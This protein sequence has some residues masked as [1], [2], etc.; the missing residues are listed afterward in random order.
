MEHTPVFTIKWALFEWMNE[1]MAK[2]AREKISFT[3]YG[4]RMNKRKIVAQK[5]TKT[6]E[7]CQWQKVCACV[8]KYVRKSIT[9]LL[10]SIEYSRHLTLCYTFQWS[11][12]IFLLIFVKKIWCQI[13]DLKLKTNLQVNFFIAEN[14]SN[15]RKNLPSR[16]GMYLAFYTLNV[17]S[18]KKWSTL[19]TLVLLCIRENKRPKCGS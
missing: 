15:F 2:Y 17:N 9:S 18:D 19:I 1:W 14:I 11:R 13:P 16:F 6:M 8:S 10:H 5:I 12:A 3:L 7:Q 4:L